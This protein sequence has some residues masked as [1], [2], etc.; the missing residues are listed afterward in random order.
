VE[1][2]VDLSTW[3]GV[4]PEATADR[5]HGGTFRLVFMGRLVAWKAV[6]LTLQAVTLCRSAGHDVVLDILGDGPERQ[7]LE[8]LCQKLDIGEFV[9][10]HGFQPQ[11][12]CAR[13]L[14]QSNALILNSVRECGGAVVLEA[15]SLGLPVIA[16][17]W[18]GPADYV[19]AS[20]G[21]LVSPIPRADF[22]A[23]LAEAISRL[24]VDP[25]LCR[26]MG[27]AG[28]AKILMEYDWEKKVD[29]MLEIYRSVL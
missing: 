21:I 3:G 7:T 25:E 6:E 28:H 29:R 1:N 11:V 16:A 24:A 8:A 15:M 20:C 27:E 5:A 12:E 10:F 17:D 13:V 26:R 22:A 18:G 9:H 14:R 23:R 4:I 19:D 2:G